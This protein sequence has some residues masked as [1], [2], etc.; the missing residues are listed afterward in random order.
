[1]VERQLPKLNVAGSSPVFRS[2]LK[3]SACRL[4]PGLFLRK[5]TDRP[6]TLRPGGPSVFWEGVFL[7]LE[8]FLPEGLQGRQ[9][10]WCTQQGI[11]NKPGTRP[12]IL[13]GLPKR[14]GRGSFRRLVMGTVLAV[15][16]N[17]VAKQFL[18]GHGGSPFSSSGIFLHC[19]TFYGRNLSYFAV[20]LA[21]P[22]SACYQYNT[23]GQQGCRGGDSPD[24][25]GVGGGKPAL[26]GGSGVVKYGGF[27][28]QRERRE[29]REQSQEESRRKKGV[30][31]AGEEK[32]Q[33][34]R[35]E[36]GS[37]GEDL[38]VDT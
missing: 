38:K 35:V 28:S 18:F 24:R 14:T 32:G 31:Q 12:V 25:W 20:S 13:Q 29:E 3:A 6:D 1:M 21:F 33:S 11:V 5:K 10:A 37:H 8:I 15:G 26:Q 34:W 22:Y 36:P 9:G 30:Q 19:S 27:L 23:Q 4:Q 17:V 16:V 2:S 7:Q